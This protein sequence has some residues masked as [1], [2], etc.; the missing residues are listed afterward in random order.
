MPERRF[1]YR[2][3]RLWRLIVTTCIQGVGAPVV[4]DAFTHDREGHSYHGKA[5][6]LTPWRKTRHGE[7]ARGRALVVGWED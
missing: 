6:H 2:G 1:P 3:Q 7:R 5:I 4:D